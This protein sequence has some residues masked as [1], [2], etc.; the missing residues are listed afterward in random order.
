MKEMGNK[1]IGMVNQ[2]FELYLHENKIEFFEYGFHDMYQY[3]H[4]FLQFPHD[5]SA[6][7]FD[8]FNNLTHSS[9]DDDDS[10]ENSSLNGGGNS[11]ESS[12]LE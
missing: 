4:I 8:T 2:M 10:D 11:D 5:L 6:E 1:L 7:I 3:L 12:D 9:N